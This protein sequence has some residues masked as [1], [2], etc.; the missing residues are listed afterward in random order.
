MIGTFAVLVIV[1]GVLAVATVAALQ[2]QHDAEKASTERLALQ[3]RASAAEMADE[4]LPLRAL[5][6]LAADRLDR[7]PISRVEMLATVERARLITVRL[8]PRKGVGYGALWADEELVAA[9][10]GDGE[11]TVWPMAGGEPDRASARSFDIGRTPLAMARRP[12]SSLLAVGGGD[13]RADQGGFPGKDG[14]AYLVDLAAMT[15]ERLAL[16]GESPVSA[17]AFIG[18]TLLVGRWDGTIAVVDTIAPGTPVRTVLAVPTAAAV[19]PACSAPEVAADSK[20]RALAVDASRRWLAAG[21]N[22]CLVAVWDLQALAQPPQVL[23]GHTGKVRTLA[24][25]P[26]TTTLLSSGDDRSIRRWDVGTATNP[27]TVLAGSADDQRVI[28]LCVAPDGR[29]VI[30]AGRDHRPA[31]DVRRD[32]VDAR[33]SGVLRP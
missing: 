27:S 21:T 12:G 1:A 9:G 28:T 6:V 19:P 13:G 32:D 17:L 31:V 15:P 18:D 29:T 26:G 4:Q 5:L 2:A 20:V 30:T 33:P 16:D 3:L 24:F 23:V 14:A 25:V 8:E 10:D 22:N 11:V 7:T